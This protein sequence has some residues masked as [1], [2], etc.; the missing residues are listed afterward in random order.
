MNRLPALESL[1]VF[2]VAAR[3][4]NFTRA[5][6]ELHVTH[7]AISQRMKALEQELGVALFER[8]GRSMAVTPQGILLSEHIARGVEEFRRGV[9]AVRAQPVERLTVSTIP[10]FATRWLIPRLP[11]FARSHP[12]ASVSVR[13]EMTL[14]SMVSDGVEIA[15]RFGEGKWPDVRVEKLFDEYLFPVHSP[16]LAQVDIPSTPAELLEHSLLNDERQPWSLYFRSLGLR[17]PDTIR[18]PAYNDTNVLLEAAAN[19][20]GITLARATLVRSDIKSGRLK[21]VFNHAV[22]TRYSY[23]LVE[24]LGGVESPAAGQFKDWIMREAHEERR[25]LRILVQDMEQAGEGAPSPAS[26]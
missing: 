25:L 12:D 18:G 8:R 14:S 7:G 17:V 9:R 24:P 16:S 13:T 21:R 4:A 26:S 6:E 20:H 5:A 2:E 1:R 10:A 3:H 11:M 15:V 22:K 19:G 23:Y